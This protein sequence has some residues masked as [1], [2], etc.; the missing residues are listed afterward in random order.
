M[1]DPLKIEALMANLDAS[2]RVHGRAQFFAW[3]Q[4]LLQM[5]IP[6]EV[7]V[8]ALRSGEALSFRADSF[9]ATVPDAAVF[10]SLF[11][12][13]ACVAHGLLKAWRAGRFRPLHYASVVDSPLAGG[14]FARELERAGVIQVVAH[15]CHDAAGEASAFF[16]FACRPAPLAAE[17][18][19]LAQLAVPCLHAAWLRALV[20]SAGE[21]RRP[22]LR[23][24]MLTPREREIL[25][26]IYLGKS[27][28]EVGGILSI[29]PL[30]VKN[31]VQKILRKLNVVNRTQ[32]V[33]KG[34]AARLF[35]P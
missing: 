24:G 31:H 2:L 15:G 10:G 13:D 18:A 7:L 5:L 29:S 35:A 14:A 33:G 34:L 27:N 25:R 9:S 21:G 23:V 26:W 19:H 1:L 32:A 17:D 16:V 6:H 12:R 22:A 4:G 11:E 3:S 8:C 28:F 20:E 30:T